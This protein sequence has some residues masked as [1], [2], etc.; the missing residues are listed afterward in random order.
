[1]TRS[2]KGTRASPKLMILKSRGAKPHVR[3]AYRGTSAANPG[4]LTVEIR[5]AL[6]LCCCVKPQRMPSAATPHL[7]AELVAMTPNRSKRRRA[8]DLSGRSI[9]TQ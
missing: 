2:V 7:R 9:R 6:S 3:D 1:V 4:A 8:T 5:G